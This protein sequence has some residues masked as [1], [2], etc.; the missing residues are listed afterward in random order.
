MEEKYDDFYKKTRKQISGFLEK[1][2]FKY[3][4]IL[5]LAPD[6]FHLLVK[7]SM[8]K[9]IPSDKKLKFVVGIAYFIMPFD[10]FPEAIL[11]PIGYMDD[12]AV[13]A[14]ILNDYINNNSPDIVYEHWAG[15]GDLLASIQNILTVADNFL[16]KGLWDRIKKKVQS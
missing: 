9:R 11:G 14:Y 13:A 16:G 1:K 6:F 3:A 12:I 8:D 5:L 10:F 4:E 2:N 15:E 7:L